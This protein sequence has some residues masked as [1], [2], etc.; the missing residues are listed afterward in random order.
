MDCCEALD[1]RGETLH[2][3]RPST[4]NSAGPASSNIW[5]CSAGVAVAYL[6]ASHQISAAPPALERLFRGV[7]NVHNRFGHVVEAI[8]TKR[9]QEN[10]ETSGTR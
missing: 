4:G 10:S 5:G 9:T 6:W 1:R 8:T 3:T 2:R 7:I